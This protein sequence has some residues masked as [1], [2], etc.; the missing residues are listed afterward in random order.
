MG[1]MYFKKFKLFSGIKIFTS[2][3]MGDSSV[4]NLFYAQENNHSVACLCCVFR[5]YVVSVCLVCLS[6]NFNLK[7]NTKI[8][9][10]KSLEIS[11]VDIAP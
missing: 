3:K 11:Q 8:L 4:E 9:P 1:S 6:Q 7:H 10:F 2:G 5:N